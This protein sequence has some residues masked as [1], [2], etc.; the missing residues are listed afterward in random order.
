MNGRRRYLV[1]GCGPAAVRACEAIRGLDPEGEI[2]V[3]GREPEGYYS[4][5]GLAYFL[6]DEVS[7]RG[8]F[9]LDGRT[10]ALLG[11]TYVLGVVRE[12]RA[13]EHEVVLE[14]GRTIS[15]DRLLLATGSRAII[16]SVEGAELDGVVKLDNLEDARA[17][18]RRSR[19]A[20][21]AVVVG[22]GITALEIV[23]GLVARKV[24]VHYLMRKDR[25]WSNVLAEPESRQVEQRLR[26]CGVELH[27]F[28]ELARIGGRDGRV[29]AVETAK[30]E[31]IPCQMVGLAIGV[32]PRKDIAEAAGL[33]CGRGVI[34]DEHLRSSD[35]DIFAAGDLAETRD[36]V[37][38][39]NTLEVLWSSAVEKGWVAGN[40]MAA[41]GEGAVAPAPLGYRKAVALNVTR[42]AGYRVIIMGRVGSGEDA[43]VKGVVRGDSE[44][45]SRLGEATTIISES[46]EG[47]IRLVLGEDSV[48]GA[49]VMGDQEA[50]FALQGLIGFRVPLG[51]AREA[52]LTPRSDLPWLLDV[53]WEGYR[54]R[55]TPGRDD[56]A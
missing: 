2:T 56:L 5:P 13:A 23:E 18:I 16:P 19:R 51:P 6:A 3:V 12:L 48:I 36:A 40:N 14:D 41:G 54:Q 1:V 53:L 24:R 55:Q 34:V 37:T 27:Y 42:L 32:S 4:R 25:Y 10:L 50:S 46:R 38:G 21:A 7:E 9:P 28:T 29:A 47:H 15:Y 11:V 26:D 44:T 20:R 17:I 8:L 39:R 35:P 52:L 43:D 22:G 33:E 30:G 45:W 49:V 31:E